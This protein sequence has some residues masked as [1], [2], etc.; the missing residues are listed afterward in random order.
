MTPF[1]VF[2]IAFCILGLLGT[3]CDPAHMHKGGHNDLSRWE[4]FGGKLKR[5]AP[6]APMNRKDAA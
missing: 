6:P 1:E 4:A 5:P 2:L 3:F